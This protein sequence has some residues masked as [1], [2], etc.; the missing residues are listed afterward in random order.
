MKT[1][2]IETWVWLLIY[3]GMLLA[4]LGLFVYRSEPALGWLLCIGGGTAAAAGVL[5]I[6][7][8][9]RMRP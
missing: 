7:L 2:T 3:G 9:S 4:C 6:F 8:R 5:L 1:A